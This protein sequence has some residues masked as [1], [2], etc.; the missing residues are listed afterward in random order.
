MLNLMKIRPE[1]A[2]LFYADRRTDG[3]KDTTKLIVAVRNFT[4]APK[5]E[6]SSRKNRAEDSIPLT[7]T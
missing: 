1:G 4:N 2:E 3:Q 7:E 5:N 6:F